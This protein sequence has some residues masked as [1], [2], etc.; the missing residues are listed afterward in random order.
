MQS[1]TLNRQHCLMCFKEYCSQ[2]FTFVS[3][4]GSELEAKRLQ[5]I[6]G[7]CLSFTRS[8][9]SDKT[10]TR[11]RLRLRLRFGQD[12][13]GLKLGKFVRDRLY[14]SLDCEYLE[15]SLSLILKP[16]EIQK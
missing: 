16:L 11:L 1:E 10:K 4:S 15:A 6:P 13:I 12:L 3:Q 2:N 5:N 14:F 7:F 9:T 8:L